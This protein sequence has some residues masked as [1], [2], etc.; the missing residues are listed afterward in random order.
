[1]FYTD[2]IE[3]RVSRLQG[4]S[5]TVRYVN[6]LRKMIIPSDRV[7]LGLTIAD[8]GLWF[9][10]YEARVQSE[11]LSRTGGMGTAFALMAAA[12][13]VCAAGAVIVALIAFTTRYAFKRNGHPM[14]AFLMLIAF[15]LGALYPLPPT[16]EE[17]SFANYQ[18]DYI[19]V[20][21]LA[22]GHQ[23]RHTGE[24]QAET[25][26]AFPSNYAHLNVGCVFVEN[27]ST[28]FV[29]FPSQASNR[30]IV[31]VEEPG[32]IQASVEPCGVNGS[33]FKQLNEHWYICIQA[34]D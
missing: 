8:L 18:A 32:S 17:A 29:E 25:A 11:G 27:T 22:R 20:V 24:C 14:P 21:E 2:D 1:M 6:S 30:V 3:V 34:I 10:V 15:I 13:V 5:D 12:P 28:F 4:R 23:L 26:F 16:P 7:G 9:V 33:T 19:R 31:Y